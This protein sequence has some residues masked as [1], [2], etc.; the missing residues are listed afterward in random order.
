HCRARDRNLCASGS[1]Q[2]RD[3]Y[4]NSH[5]AR[6]RTAAGRGAHL[7]SRRAEPSQADRARQE[8]RAHAQAAARGARWGRA[9]ARR[10]AA[11]LS[12]STV[13]VIG[14]GLLGEALARRLL[15]GGFAVSGYDLEPAKTARLAGL[16]GTAA[17][18]IAAVAKDCQTIVLAVFSTEQVEAVLEHE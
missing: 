9:R 6:C 10:R 12:K 16:S 13:G 14:L 3:R 2:T 8:R 18:S 11:V 15:A 17:A 7:A 1:V 4:R 5:H